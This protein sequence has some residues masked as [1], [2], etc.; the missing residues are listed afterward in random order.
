[1]IK[2]TRG[3]PKKKKND[4]PESESNAKEGQDKYVYGMQQKIAKKK[5]KY[6]DFFAQRKKILDKNN[7]LESSEED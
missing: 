7:H 1:M 3:V 4:I 2:V 6:E 5:R